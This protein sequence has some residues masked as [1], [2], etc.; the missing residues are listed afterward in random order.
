MEIVLS[1]A[2]GIL[3]GSGIWLI[4]RPR[5]ARRTTSRSAVIAKDITIAVRTRACGRGSA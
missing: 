2:I 1:L 4:L 3:T 5:E